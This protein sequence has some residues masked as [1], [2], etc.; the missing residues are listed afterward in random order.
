LDSIVARALLVADFI[1]SID[2]K[3]TL[4]LCEATLDCVILQVIGELAR[5]RD[6]KRDED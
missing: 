2:P 6:A 5:I 4:G 3:L 1:D